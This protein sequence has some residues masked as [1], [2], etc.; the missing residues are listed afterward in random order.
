MYMYECW[1]VLLIKITRFRH[2]SLSH[3]RNSCGAGPRRSV[4]SVRTILRVL[5]NSNIQSTVERAFDKSVVSGSSPACMHTHFIYTSRYPIR[6]HTPIYICADTY[7]ASDGLLEGFN[8][9]CTSQSLFLSHSLACSLRRLLPPSFL[10]FWQSVCLSFPLCSS[11]ACSDLSRGSL[12][13]TSEKCLSAHRV[14]PVPLPL[15][16]LPSRVRRARVPASVSAFESSVPLLSFAH[17][18]VFT[19]VHIRVCARYPSSRVLACKDAHI[20]TEYRSLR[21]LTGET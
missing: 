14:S 6:I 2:A 3:S 9:I 5:W 1:R 21:F 19:S 16:S 7:L 20:H 15:P 12:A 18:P 11:A 4:F 13:S 8:L 17:G 10:P